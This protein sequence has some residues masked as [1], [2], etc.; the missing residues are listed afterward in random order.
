LKAVERCFAA[1]IRGQ[2][3]EMW[4]MSALAPDSTAE[5]KSLG[6]LLH[7]PQSKNFHQEVRRIGENVSHAPSLARW[8]G[9]SLLALSTSLPAQADKNVREIVIH[10]FR[11]GRPWNTSRP[12]GDDPGNSRWLPT[13]RQTDEASPDTGARIRRGS[14]SDF[15]TRSRQ[16]AD[17][18]KLA[19][20]P[21]GTCRRS[22]AR[23]DARCY[24]APKGVFRIHVYRPREDQRHCSEPFHVHRFDDY[25]HAEVKIKFSD[26]SQLT[27]TSH[28][29]YELM[30]PWTI[31]GSNSQE[32]YN[33]DISRAIS[34]T[35]ATA[36][37]RIDVSISWAQ[38]GVAGMPS[39]D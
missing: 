7:T 29:Y 33:A 28:S 24:S 5:R 10:S 22:N 21:L 25:P 30:L 14:P 2:T 35:A 13:G 4:L 18:Q 17:N 27:L 1:A 23:E 38:E 36:N 3:P 12:N 8:I 16:L 37:L 26:G 39:D 6:K 34:P 32:T 9:L 31:D 19:S 15:Q 20:I 11:L